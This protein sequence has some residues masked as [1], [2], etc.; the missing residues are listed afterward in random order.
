MEALEGGAIANPDEGRMVGH[1][2]LRAPER[3]P[4]R[5]S[6][7]P[8]GR[9][10]TAFSISPRA[11]RRPGEAA[12]GRALPALLVVGIG[13]SALGP[14]SWPMPSAVRPTE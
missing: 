5:R 14:S 7:R 3:A 12:E 8:S 11:S 1:Y 2:W 6:P 4:R 9:P 13:G 10:A